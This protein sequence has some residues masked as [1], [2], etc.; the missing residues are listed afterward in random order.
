MSGIYVKT[1]NAVGDPFLKALLEG[2]LSGATKEL[3]LAREKGW[4]ELRLYTEMFTPALR[5]IGDLWEKG[6]AS[7]AQE[8]LAVQITLELLTRVRSQ[9]QPA[10]SAG[11]RILVTTPPG[12]THWLGARMAADFFELSGLSTDFL[13]PDT[14]VAELV[15]YVQQQSHG[16]V[17]LSVT[18][19]DNLKGAQA[20]IRALRRLSPMVPV[21][22]GGQMAE[23]ARSWAKSVRPDAIA[24]DPLDGFTKACRLLRLDAGGISFATVLK[25]VGSR[26]ESLRKERGWSQQE[27]ANRTDLDRTYISALES[28]KQNAT[29]KVLLK[30]C[31]ALSVPL[32]SMF[33][34]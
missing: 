5:T 9:F 26:I 34:R 18:H 30:V 29:I 23:R 16:M 20:V 27:L 10:A 6:E 25:R 2:R 33:S 24:E 12:E 1:E 28:G 7:V 11:K 8:H 15:N 21:L 22:L 3:E 32:D 19:P 14:P 13:G 31:E 17:A 4:S